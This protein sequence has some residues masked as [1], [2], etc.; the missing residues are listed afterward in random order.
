M[1]RGGFRAQKMRAT[2]TRAIR[3]KS[4]YAHYHRMDYVSWSGVSAL[5]AAATLFV[6]LLTLFSRFR[7]PVS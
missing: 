3:L 1:R 7:T 5:C 4:R 6:V 2:R